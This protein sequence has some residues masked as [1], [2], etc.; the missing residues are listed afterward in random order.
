MSVPN[1]VWV[2]APKEA[3]HCSPET[4]YTNLVYWL[5]E[6]G[7]VK[8]VWVELMEDTD[9]EGWYEDQGYSCIDY[10]PDEQPYYY[11]DELVTR[12]TQKWIP[13]VGRS[14]ERRVGKERRT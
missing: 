10:T 14:E 11:K 8:K 12:P 13:R 4:S 1:D 2:K 5:I 6:G 9:G 7:V 3:T